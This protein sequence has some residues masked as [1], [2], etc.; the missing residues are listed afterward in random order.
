MSDGDESTERK[1]E[2]REVTNDEHVRIFI[3]M[4]FL[5]Q[6]TI[7]LF[8]ISFRSGFI[9]IQKLVIIFRTMN[10]GDEAEEN[11]GRKAPHI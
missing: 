9:D 11:E 10:Q 3:G 4:I 6:R 5:A 8:D 2:R 7:G 1:R